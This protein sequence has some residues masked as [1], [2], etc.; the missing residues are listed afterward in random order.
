MFS[1]V[2]Q[3]CRVM[4]DHSKMSKMQSWMIPSVKNE[5]FL[6]Y[7]CWM[8]LILHMIEPNVF[9]QLGLGSQRSERLKKV[10]KFQIF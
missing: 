6:T 2:R 4:T 10:K 7:G 9:Q 5:V 8:D 3:G 1:K